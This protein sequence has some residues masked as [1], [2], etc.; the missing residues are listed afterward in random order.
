MGC[1]Q[2]AAAY[3]KRLLM[4]SP[5]VVFVTRFEVPTESMLRGGPEHKIQHDFTANR[6]RC[7][8]VFRRM[9]PRRTNAQHELR[10]FRERPRLAC[11]AGVTLDHLRAMTHPRLCRAARHSQPR[12]RHT[13]FCLRV[14]D[15]H[16]PR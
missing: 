7:H 3:A 13:Q 1:D 16:W 4:A 11:P 15:S 14:S 5:K 2:Q 12:E 10:F 6:V 8:A 9:N